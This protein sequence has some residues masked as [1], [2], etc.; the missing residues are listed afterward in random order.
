MQVSVNE[1]KFKALKGGHKN[2]VDISS[3]V[4]LSPSET[5]NPSHAETVLVQAVLQDVYYTLD[6]TT[7]T[8]TLGYR[9]TAG[10]DPYVIPVKG[11]IL[12]VIQGAA[13]PGFQFTFGG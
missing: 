3:A 10:N 6:G 8:S 11:N 13:T 5:H 1:L 2:A 7:P 12:T 9:I 4:V